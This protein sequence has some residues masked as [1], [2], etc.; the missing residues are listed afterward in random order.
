MILLDQVY[1]GTQLVQFYD[2]VIKFDKESTFFVYLFNYIFQFVYLFCSVFMVI[3]YA[4]K[5]PDPYS[6][7]VGGGIAPIS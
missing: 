1:Q 2:D 7:P 6:I 3:L 5:Y 4:C